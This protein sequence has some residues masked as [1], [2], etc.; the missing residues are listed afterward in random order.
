VV[1]FNK[2]KNEK[3]SGLGKNG[4]VVGVEEGWKKTL[5]RRRWL[6]R[7]INEFM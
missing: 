5:S 6:G 1:K 3:H 2:H 4:S 7:K